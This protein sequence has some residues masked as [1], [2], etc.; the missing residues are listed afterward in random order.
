MGLEP[1][2]ELIL[3]QRCTAG[4]LAHL[5]RIPGDN[6][7]F[8]GMQWRID[9]RHRSRFIAQEMHPRAHRQ[10]GL[11]QRVYRRRGR[12]AVA[13]ATCRA[14]AEA[15]RGGQAAHLLQPVAANIQLLA[16]EAT[17]CEILAWGKVSQCMATG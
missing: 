4:E 13:E 2:C 3:A 14:V 11:E 17:Q 12:R 7:E 1:F 9:D 5:R 8:W 10:Q 6:R 15:T 16:A